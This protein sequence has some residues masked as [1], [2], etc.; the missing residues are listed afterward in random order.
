MTSALSKRLL[1][2][3]L[4]LS[5]IF[6][7]GP[8]L[9]LRAAEAAP[10]GKAEATLDSMEIGEDRVILGLSAPAKYNS[11]MTQNPHRLVIE[12]LDTEYQL[13]VNSVAGKGKYL[14]RVR[15]SQNQVS[16]RQL[17]RVAIDLKEKADYAIVPKG[18]S[19]TVEFLAVAG[20]DSSPVAPVATSKPMTPKASPDRRQDVTA[21]AAAPTPPVAASKPAAPPVAAP[22]TPKASPDRRQDVAAPA[23][24]P[25]P[26]QASAPVPAPVTASAPK[27]TVRPKAAPAPVAAASPIS[28]PAPTELG[29]MAAQLDKTKT[30]RSYD[31]PPVRMTDAV[32]GAA[33]SAAAPSAFKKGQPNQCVPTTSQ[34]CDIMSRLP[35][36]LV[37]FDFDNTD[38]KDILK[39]LAIKSKVNI[40]HGSDV[41]GTLTL[42]LTDV[43]FND[44]FRTILMMT[45]MVP[46]QVGENI[47]RV[48]TLSGLAG[49]VTTGV[50]KVVPINY[51]K[52][53]DVSAAVNAVR[54]AEGRQGSTVVDS[55]N[56]AL[57][58]TETPEGMASTERLIRQL[59]VKPKQVVIE[60]KFI[61]VQHS[62]GFQFGIK[63]DYFEFDPGRALGKNGATVI[64]SEV[65]PTKNPF[66]TPFHEDGITVTPPPSQG[67]GVNLPLAGFGA[68]TLGRVTNNY[69]LNVSLAAAANKGKIKVLS[70]PKIATLN[71][72]PASINLNSQIPYKTT[73]ISGTGANLTQT[74]QPA[75]APSGIQ[76]TVTPTINADGR[77]TIDLNP[78]VSNSVLVPPDNLPKTDTRAAKTILVVNDGETVVIGG[79]ISD[80][81]SIGVEKIPL[82]GD[83]PLLGWL[84][85]RKIVVRNRTELL[86]FVTPKIMPD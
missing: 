52:A 32:A 44:A 8:A 84:F 31:A 12:F 81:Q 25:A 63:W 38:I 49:L 37:T 41:S 70:D 46:I 54:T 66:N 76:L 85:K 28:V 53:V 48:G 23:A 39:L 82:L 42:H 80:Q 58:I 21:P 5:M 36:D 50:T 4:T 68:F 47:L 22:M 60:V 29:S 10:K 11:F 26:V 57:V 65:K 74:T 13:G 62:R 55:K 83:L 34:N 73:T 2:A 77:I 9:D 79:L 59:D 78:S 69:F 6:P 1:A 3:L 14:L 30:L 20:G 67:T 33:V 19:I 43:P 40:I 35:S 71:N 7:A 86:I 56:N 61:E 75:F 45:K 72:V 64:G 18:N 15:S 24:T 17:T 51:M 27:P 16:P